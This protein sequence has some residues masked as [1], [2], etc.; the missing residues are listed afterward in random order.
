FDSGHTGPAPTTD[1]STHESLAPTSDDEPVN[2]RLRD[3][4][5][6]APAP[7]RAF[8]AAPARH[9]PQESTLFLSASPVGLRPAEI[10]RPCSRILVPCRELSGVG[11]HRGHPYVVQS[12]LERCTARTTSSRAGRS[13]TRRPSDPA[14]NRF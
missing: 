14:S 3:R 1:P 4:P 9:V 5:A 8:G 11:G 12:M 6:R 13:S 10:R 7:V 2:A